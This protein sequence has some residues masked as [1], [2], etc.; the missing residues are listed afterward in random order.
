MTPGRPNAVRSRSV[1]IDELL[2]YL[3]RLAGDCQAAGDHEPWAIEF[4]ELDRRLT[5]G[6][7]LP[8][9][10]QRARRGR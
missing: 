9:E 3:R 4:E 5:N 10:W 8:T 2:A 7:E 1:K 6:G